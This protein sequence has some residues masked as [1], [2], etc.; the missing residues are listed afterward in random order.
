MGSLV[1][2]SRSPSDR[3]HRAR[4]DHSREIAEDYVELIEQL[5]AERGEARVTDLASAIGVSKVTVSRT[6]QR[7]QR[8]GFVRSE[9]Y[10]SVFLTDLG[11]ELAE[12]ARKRHEIVLSFLRAL[13]VSETAAE[14]DAE[15]IEHHV[16][17]ES[18]AA[19]R[20]FVEQS[21]RR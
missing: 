15:G 14:N 11:K 6:I 19:M 13:G 21:R 18:L 8:D 4:A 9:P 17:E 5:I 1:M 20:R 7:L 16:S 12:K 3:F 2:L 10:R